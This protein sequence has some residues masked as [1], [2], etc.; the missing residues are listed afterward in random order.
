MID[1]MSPRSAALE[2][3]PLVAHCAAATAAH[4]LLRAWCE[5]RE[6]LPRIAELERRR[7]AVEAEDG[8]ARPAFHAQTPDLLAD[9]LHYETRIAGRG[10]LATR[11]GSAHDVFNALVWLRH[12]HLKWALNARQVADIAVAGPRV[13]TRGQCALTHFDEAGAIVWLADD[14]LAAAWD[15]HDWRAL[16]VDRRDD[17]G[18]RIAV[19][20]F[21]HALVEHVWQGHVLPVAKCLAV[22][23]DAGELVAQGDGQVLPGA[24]PQMEARIAAAIR[25]GD[26]LAD[27]QELRP[28]P[29][30]GLRGW[31]AGDTAAFVAAAPCFRPLRAGRRYPLPWRAGT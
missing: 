30:A 15:A 27:P 1:A 14:T 4:P 12:P 23:V 29:L 25:R 3:A 18:R 31:H 9:R 13:R 2:R 21:G 22:R 16:F 5:P 26:L 17:W 10:V 8:I 11:D 19:T 20:V 28:L 6:S 7:H 24:W